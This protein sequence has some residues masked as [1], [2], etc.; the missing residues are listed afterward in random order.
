MNTRSYT[1]LLAVGMIAA[2]LM[3]STGSPSAWAERG[4]YKWTDELGN[5][6]RSD[7]PPPIGIEYEF[8]S[9]DTGLTRQVSAEESRAEA[10]NST[11]P[12]DKE[13]DATAP[14][15]GEPAAE[16]DPALCEQARFN[17][18]SLSTSARIRLKGA[19]GEFRYLT[20]EEKQAQREKAEGLIE[21]HCD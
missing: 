8:V 6:H 4:Y 10:S 15:G 5:Q 17:L 14:G 20:E 9:T 12:A 21:Q 1:L 11:V 7:R 2:T 19:D 16:K 3:L 18:N 13:A